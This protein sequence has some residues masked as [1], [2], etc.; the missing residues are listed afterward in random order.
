MKTAILFVTLLFVF[1]SSAYAEKTDP[2]VDQALNVQFQNQDALAQQPAM[3]DTSVE[4]PIAP[5]PADLTNVQAIQESLI[6]NDIQH[7]AHIRNQAIADEVIAERETELIADE[8]P[9]QENP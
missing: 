7:T 1:F 2:A 5:V 8:E 3:I 9:A 4:T 6:V